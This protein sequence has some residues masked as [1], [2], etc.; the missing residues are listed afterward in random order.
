M[1]I[2]PMMKLAFLTMGL[3]AASAARILH[4]QAINVYVQFQ[5]ENVIH[6]VMKAKR[7]SVKIHN[8]NI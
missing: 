2:N 4:A 8:L 1:G 7:Q 5:S 6:L 3:K